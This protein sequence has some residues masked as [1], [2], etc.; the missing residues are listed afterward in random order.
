MLPHIM[1][2]TLHHF[3][4]DQAHCYSFAAILYLNRE[5]LFLPSYYRTNLMLDNI[6]TDFDAKHLLSCHVVL[7]IDL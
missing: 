2:D 7:S 4:A 6:D 3:I 5:M 1:F